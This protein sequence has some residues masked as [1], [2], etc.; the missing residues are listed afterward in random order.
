MLVKII[1][2]GYIT[3]TMTCESCEG[4]LTYEN[5]NYWTDGYCYEVG[6]NMDKWVSQ[7]NL[8]RERANELREQRGH[9]D[10]LE[11]VR[12]KISE[13]NTKAS[14]HL[15]VCDNCGEVDHFETSIG[16]G[17][18]EISRIKKELD[19]I[20]KRQEKEDAKRLKKEKKKKKLLEKKKQMIA[21]IDDELNELDD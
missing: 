3:K 18:S 20:Q 21:E 4:E 13:F 7:R 8:L 14:I 5:L 17:Y 9:Q 16:K 19:K 6:I 2:W 15:L 10:D 12:E 1:Y 11:A